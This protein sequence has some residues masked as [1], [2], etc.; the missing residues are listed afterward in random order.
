[1]DS[2]DTILLAEVGGRSTDGAREIAAAGAGV[3]ESR[4]SRREP[5]FRT[6]AASFQRHP[7]SC[8]KN[9]VGDAAS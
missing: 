1:M 2:A 9:P 6:P 4:L 7:P 8:S 5:E 3:A